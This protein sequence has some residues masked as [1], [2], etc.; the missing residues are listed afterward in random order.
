MEYNSLIF[1]VLTYGIP[2]FSKLARDLIT[3]EIWLKMGK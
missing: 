1:M 3:E 2:T